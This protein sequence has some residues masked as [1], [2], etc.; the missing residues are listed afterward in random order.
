ML[1]TI[2]GK[3]VAGVAAVLLLA[4]GTAFGASNAGEKLQDWYNKLF[5]QHAQMV[6]TGVNDHVDGLMPKLRNEYQG[7]KDT[8]ATD[9]NKF[10]KDATGT[11]SKSINNQAGEYI[12]AI[13]E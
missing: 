1:K 13:K 2:K 11:T 8:A 4:G 10:G 12:G 7:I 5:N 3:V 6:E 9:I